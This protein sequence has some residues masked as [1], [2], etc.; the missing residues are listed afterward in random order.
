MLLDGFVVMPVC[1]RIPNFYFLNQSTKQIYAESC[2]HCV[3]V[4]RR[5]VVGRVACMPVQIFL[6]QLSG[7]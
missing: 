1:A 7:E 6:D 3:A 2:N 5:Q 4:S